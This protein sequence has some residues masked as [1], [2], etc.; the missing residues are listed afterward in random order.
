MEPA[1][2]G[3]HWDILTAH[4][5]SPSGLVPCPQSQQGSFQKFYKPADIMSRWE[6]V[7]HGHWP[8]LQIGV[9]SRTG[10]L[11]YYTSA[12]MTCPPSRGEETFWLPSQGRP[13]PLQVLELTLTPSSWDMNICTCLALSNLTQGTS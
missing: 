7:H 8:T 3:P 2:L 4:Q 1:E 13:T 5:V 12:S 6:Y 10:C 11:L 9:V